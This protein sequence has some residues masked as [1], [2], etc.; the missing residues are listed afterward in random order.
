MK[1]NCFLAILLVSAGLLV[2]SC[3]SDYRL[4]VG[5]YTDKD[6]E[7]GFSVFGFNPKTGALTPVKSAD[8]GPNP[9][10]FCFSQKNNL[11]YA[12]NEVM[13]FRG[14]ATGG[15]TTLQYNPD[16]NSLEKKGEIA[17]PNGGPCFISMSPDSGYLFA[18]NYPGGSVA[19]VKLNSRGVPESVTDTIIFHKEKPDGSHA[20]MILGAP[21]GKIIYVTDLG[22]D[23]IRAFDFDTNTGRLNLKEN[24]STKIS[25][26]SGPRHFTFN[27][28]GTI[29]YLINELGSEI[30]V[31]SVK[32]DGSLEQLQKVSTLRKDYK[33]ENACADIHLGKD[34]RFLYGS[35]RGENSIVTFRVGNDGLLT[36]AGSTSCGGNWPR[37]FVIDPTGNFLLV[38]NERSDN[39][40]VFRIDRKTGLPAH[41]TGM[42]ETKRP[43]CLKVYRFN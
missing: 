9:S 16:N 34:G 25:D 30:M 2:S 3:K 1:K 36:L 20:H 26:G 19:V 35:N 18:A 41:Q 23:L 6:G 24:G 13:Q 37:N 15:I 40:A 12:A 5:G 4:F 22:M 39:I 28:N 11:F 8:A 29:L 31:F 27:S 32:S 14:N 17:F 7:K 43:S 21:S 33:G 42:A 38:G 10:Y